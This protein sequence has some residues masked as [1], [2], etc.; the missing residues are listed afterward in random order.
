MARRKKQKLLRNTHGQAIT[1]T[2]RQDVERRSAGIAPLDRGHAEK[3][4]D[5][6]GQLNEFGYKEA[7]GRFGEVTKEVVVTTHLAALT[8]RRLARQ[9][10]PPV[11][12]SSTASKSDTLD[13]LRVIV[14]E[15]HCT[16]CPYKGM[17]ELAA[18]RYD[19]QVADA[20]YLAAQARGATAEITARLDELRASVVNAGASPSAGQ[21]ELAGPFPLP[22][23]PPTA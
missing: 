11:I 5:A 10:L 2:T 12:E 6:R 21:A 19:Q 14:G 8:C 9:G 1:T 13:H 7:G 20:D 15:L 3:Y 23:Q 17:D 18:A 4:T 22:P 16:T